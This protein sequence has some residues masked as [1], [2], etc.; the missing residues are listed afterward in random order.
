MLKFRDDKDLQELEKL[1]YKKREDFCMGLCYFK[2]ITDQ[3]CK[4]E[5]FAEVHIANCRETRVV[6]LGLNI[7]YNNFNKQTLNYYL[8]IYEN[9]LFDLIQAGLIEKVEKSNGEQ[10]K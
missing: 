7:P 2:D 10:G 6:G 5:E 1:G 9:N 3:E 8:D 4:D